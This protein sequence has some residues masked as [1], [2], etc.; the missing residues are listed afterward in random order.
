MKIS[1]PGSA[2][3]FE[4]QRH[5]CWDH[6]R[7]LLSIKQA[8]AS[9]QEL[10]E[11]WSSVSVAARC[12]LHSSSIIMYARPFT[13]AKTR[14]GKI[15]FASKSLSN[16]PGFDSELHKHILKLR[17]EIVAHSDYEHFPSTMYLQTVGDGA[18]PVSLGAKVKTMSGISSL[19]LAGR[20]KSHFL[21]AA[22]GMENLLG[23]EF[24]SLV[25]QIKRE[26]QEFLKTQ[27]IPTSTKLVAAGEVTD[28]QP[29]GPVSVVAQPAFSPGLDGYSY[30]QLTHQVAL[31]DS[32]KYQILSDGV[33]SEITFDV[34]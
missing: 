25:D 1:E 12:A 31:L 19:E 13:V 8:L 34:D 10:I 5:R 27:N 11:S 20:Y 21:A 4:H 33:P 14:T 23:K 3:W 32:G 2:A 24:K 16:E 6:L 29:S 30:V 17:D 15:I 28:A 9:I 18:L 22:L 7:A 26:P